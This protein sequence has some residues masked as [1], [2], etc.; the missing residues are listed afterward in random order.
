MDQLTGSLTPFPKDLPEKDHK[1]LT[2]IERFITDPP[3]NSRVFWI[4]PAM[5]T[6]LHAKYNVG[7]RP[8]KPAKIGEYRAV[9]EKHEWRLTGDTI[10]FSNKRLLR[11]GQNRFRACMESGEPF[12]THVVFGINDE[13]FVVMDQGKNRGGADLLAIKGVKH[14]TIVSAGVRWAHLYATDT[15]QQRTTYKPPEI[16]QLYDDRYSDM[17]AP[18]D[19]PPSPVV[20]WAM[21]VYHAQGWPP[22][23]VCGTLYH[24]AK[25]DEKAAADFAKAMST[26][27]FKGKYKPLELMRTALN[28]AGAAKMRIHDTVRAAMMLIAW[29]LVR[30]GKKGT[31]KDFIWFPADPRFP[32]PTAV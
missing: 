13:F 1:A 28:P 22:G 19:V 3:D 7:N 25:I 27:N 14:S 9:M 8:E 32:F 4:T 16:V 12:Q 10:K 11:D 24:L 6:Y 23:F 5:A 21:A 26:D 30:S 29:N 17:Q 2:A 15:V 18:G 31:P 20:S